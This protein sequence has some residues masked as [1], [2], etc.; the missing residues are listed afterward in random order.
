MTVGRASTALKTGRDYLRI[1][2]SS[3]R[4]VHRQIRF[5]MPTEEAELWRKQLIEALM[6]AASHGQDTHLSQNRVSARPNC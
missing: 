4:N 5:T 3:G 1:A 6:E 2:N